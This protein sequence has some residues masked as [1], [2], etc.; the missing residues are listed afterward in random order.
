[1][2]TINVRL[3]VKRMSGTPASNTDLLEAIES[4][5]GVL[6]IGPASDGVRYAVDVEEG[7]PHLGAL[8]AE[9]RHHEEGCAECDAYVAHVR[10]AIGTSGKG[11]K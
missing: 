9:L 11:T 6:D 5:V 10:A 8:L 2:S 1:M 7:K 3:H 4:A